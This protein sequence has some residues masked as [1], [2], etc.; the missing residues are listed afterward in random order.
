MKV[1]VHLLDNMRNGNLIREYYA[2]GGGDRF[3][4]YA[5]I[6]QAD[7]IKTFRNFG[8][9]IDNLIASTHNYH[10]VATHGT[11]TRGFLFPFQSQMPSQPGQAMGKLAKLADRLE[12][13]KGKE[14]NF[15]FRRSIQSDLDTLKRLMNVATDSDVLDFTSKLI[16]LRKR[17][18]I[19]YVRG[20]NVG[21]NLKL[22]RDY[23]A[24]LG[25]PRLFVPK[26]SNGFVRI[27]YDSRGNSSARMARHAN[28]RNTARQ[29]LRALPSTTTPHVVT[30]IVYQGPGRFGSTTWYDRTQNHP[31]TANN[32]IRNVNKAWNINANPILTFMWPDSP[33]KVYFVADHEYTYQLVLA[34]W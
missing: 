32:L 9:L 3:G 18:V 14:T 27:V 28:V 25:C 6:L 33:N 21:K 29:R 20:C 4:P 10:I 19:I 23:R 24:A 26:C 11:E 2:N 15:G 16:A 13:N 5:K 1:D 31:T 8:E 22:V 34:M 30:R 12:K 17:K 7:N